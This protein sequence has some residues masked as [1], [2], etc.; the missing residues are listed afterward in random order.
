MWGYLG[1]GVLEVVRG[2]GEVRRELVGTHVPGAVD[3]VCDADLAQHFAVLC[4]GL[5]ADVE[6][7]RCHLAAYLGEVVDLELLAVG[8]TDVEVESLAVLVRDVLVGGLL[9]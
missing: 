8:V 4:D 7:P 2:V 5:A 3:H 1:L 9:A 6:E